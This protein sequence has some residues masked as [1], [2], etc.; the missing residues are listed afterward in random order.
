M[1]PKNMKAYYFVVALSG[2]GCA[3]VAN[4]FAETL[5]TTNGID[6][7]RG[8]I[9]PATQ[10]VLSSDIDGRVLSLPF[11]EG[12]RF[13]KG[14]T[15]VKFDCDRY[16][17]ELSAAAAE[18][19]ARKKTMTNN[20]ELS[21]LNA[22]GNLEVALSKD[23]MKKAAAYVWAANVNVRSCEIRAPFS[24]RVVE[25][26]VNEFESVSRHDELL[27]VLDDNRLEVG[28]I[29]PSRWLRWLR[30]GETFSF[31]VDE[32]G[33]EHTLTVTGV[34]ATVDPVSQTIKVTGAFPEEKGRVLSGMSGT[35]HFSSTNR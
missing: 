16:R 25:Q 31:H 32:T 27:S 21:N 17:A 12:Q 9:E 10:A 34:G 7:I 13:G 23:E 11:R 19:R 15:L 20:V 2:A 4:V 26:L 8:V 35:A 33:E 22:I 5:P 1:F 3:A 6:E 18:H 14:D 24:G 30:E 29:V 28:I